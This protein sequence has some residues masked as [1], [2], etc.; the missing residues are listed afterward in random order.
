VTR[1]TRYRRSSAKRTASS[2]EPGEA[3]TPRTRLELEAALKAKSQEIEGKA[4]ELDKALA[5]I[6]GLQGF[7]GN[8]RTRREGQHQGGPRT[9]RVART[10][11]KEAMRAALEGISE[12]EQRSLEE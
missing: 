4:Q 12:T 7:V 10:E 8:A 3:R 1:R 5:E 2:R 6:A 9:R 11:P